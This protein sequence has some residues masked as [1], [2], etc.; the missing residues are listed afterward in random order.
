MQAIILEQFGGPEVLKLGTVD[1]P[2]P[3]AGQV[4]I[5][6]KATTVNRADTI[7]RLG[8]YPAPKGESELLGLEVAGTI[9]ELGPGVAGFAVGD[10]V[11][12]LVG[13]GGYAQFAAAYASHLIRIPERMSFEQAGC[14]CET[15]ITAYLNVF[16]LGRLTDGETV[17]LHGGGGGV[18]TSGIQLCRLLRPNSKII[19]TAS[20]GKVD[21][22]KALGA[23]E[24]VD[25]KAESFADA[26]RERTGKRGADMILDHIGGA[27]LAQNLA[28][29]AVAGRLVI[30]GLMGGAKAEINLGALMVKRQHVIGSVLRSRP[31]DEK[32]A[33][34]SE[35]TAEVMPLFERGEIV[36]LIDQVL[37]LG[38]AAE[39]HRIMEAS[40]HFGKIVLTP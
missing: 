23:H 22:V 21:R 39:A 26:V 9:A 34:V 27:Y 18:N 10:R 28:C 19:V 15:Y 6:V 8:H 7:Q 11:M 14:V 38:E 24:V 17:L 16:M 20:P 12:S 32:A 4:L 1:K 35:F 2:V 31:I 25:Y 5:E 13:G 29:L 33:I 37:P 3:A 36:P 30:I 40:G